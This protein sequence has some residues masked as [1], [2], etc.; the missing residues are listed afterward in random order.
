[1]P[2]P[3][4][5]V[6]AYTLHKA[7]G[8]AVA[9]F[10]GKDH[11]L[12]AYGS[13][14]SYERLLA[15]WRANRAH[16]VARSTAP[17]Q[18]S[19]TSQAG[20]A[21]VNHILLAFLKHAREY[22]VDP[23]GK[24]TSE[25]SE[26][27][28][29]LKPVR[30]LYGRVPATEFGPLALKAVRE[31]MLEKGWCRKTINNRVD[32]IK[33]AFRWAVAEE[34]V[35]SSVYEALRTVPGLRAGRTKARE[36]EPIMPVP[37]A[38]VDAILP[39]LAPPVVAMVELQWLTGIRPGEVVIMRACDIDT[40]GEV[41]LYRPHQHKNSWRGQERVVAL[42]PQ[43]Q[44]IIK[45]FLTTSTTAYLFSPVAAEAWRSQQKRQQRKTPLTPSQAKRKP[46]AKPKR[47]K[48]DR[49]DTGSYRRAISYAVRA[50][51]RKRADEEPEI[52]DWCP[53]QLRHSRA[54]EIRRQ[55][56]LEAAQVILGHSRADVTQVYAERDLTTALRVA[57]E[58]G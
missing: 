58:T 29:A 56:G 37:R 32:R 27:K 34:L 50:A 44:A 12:G 57:R 1:M 41:W 22:Y 52:P 19:P 15:E 42:G 7:S 3:A 43:A 54:T 28:Y 30:Q 55:F 36:P 26:I 39:Y 8:R 33:R 48:R 53:L 47:P 35:Q 20:A 14:E 24:A 46:K 6:P 45:Q 9:R 4:G 18:A 25:V 23:Q 16:Q 11:Y 5:K 31:W 13:P 51:K 38:Y 49:Y 10:Q 17:P 40:T 2:R 21:T